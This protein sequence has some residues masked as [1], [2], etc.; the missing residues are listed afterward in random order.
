MH[1]HAWLAVIAV[2]FAGLLLVMC[3]VWPNSALRARRRKARV[4]RAVAEAYRKERQ[5]ILGEGKPVT[6]AE[7][8]DRMA[9]EDRTARR[10]A[11]PIR[12][13]GREYGPGEDDRPTEMLPRVK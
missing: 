10:A 11:Q 13:N 9:R 8:V 1:E 2:A 7:L 3:L 4:A 6:V 12:R 5:N